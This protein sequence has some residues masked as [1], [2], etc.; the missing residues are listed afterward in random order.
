VK[1]G[2][3]DE[4][5]DVKVAGARAGSRINDFGPYLDSKI[6]ACR[7]KDCGLS[8]KRLPSAIATS[9]AADFMRASARCNG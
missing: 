7:K 3:D 2:E 5:Q 9:P 4:Q 1:Q 8:E 6:A